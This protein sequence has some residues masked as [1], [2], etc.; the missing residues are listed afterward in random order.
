MGAY[1]VLALLIAMLAM[2]TDLNF[3][4]VEAASCEEINI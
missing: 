1:K 4:G 2:F 3:T